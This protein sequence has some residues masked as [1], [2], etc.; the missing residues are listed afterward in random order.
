MNLRFN[1]L[2]LYAMAILFILVFFFLDNDPEIGKLV[3]AADVTRPA[4]GFSIF[5]LTGILA[6][7]S[8]IFGISLAGVQT[9]L[10]IRRLFR[11]NLP[12]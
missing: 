3:T 11:K 10:L 12:R 4:T 7:A 1:P 9:F 6:Y 8:L 5:F 2:G